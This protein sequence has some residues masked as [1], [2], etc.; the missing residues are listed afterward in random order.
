MGLLKGKRGLIFGALNKQSIAWITAERSVEEGAQIVLSNTEM[1]MRM[2]N[3]PELAK[4]LQTE[5]LVADATKP[6]DLEKVFDDAQKILGGKLD[7]ILH[8]IAMSPNIRKRNA[9]DKLNYDFF[10]QTLDVSALSF[11]KMLQVAKQK[12]AINDWGSVVALSFIA[13]Q[14][15]YDGYDDMADA[16]SLL[17]SIARSFGYVYGKDKHVRVNTVSQS[18]TL[19]KAGEGVQNLDKLAMYTHKMAPLGNASAYH[20]ANFCLTLFSDYTRMITMQNLYHDGGYSKM[21]MS[22]NVYQELHL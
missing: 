16:K 1:A 3:V 20:C 14:K 5:I 4:M 21:G 8:A 11:H 12:D 7:F 15:V 6:E 17:E 22:K 2:G 19:T 9:Y 13:A 10:T 18:P